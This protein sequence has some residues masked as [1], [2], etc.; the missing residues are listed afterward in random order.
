MLTASPDPLKTDMA[1]LWE[2][3]TALYTRVPQ[4]RPPFIF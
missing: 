3:R 1:L 4:K 2:H